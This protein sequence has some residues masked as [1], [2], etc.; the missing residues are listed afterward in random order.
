MVLEL[1]NK[2]RDAL[3]HA[4][5]V[6]DGQ[7]KNERVRTDDREMKECLRED[8]YLLERILQKMAGKN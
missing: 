6:L 8:Q 5:E 4:L 3:K 2:E 7:L 1:D